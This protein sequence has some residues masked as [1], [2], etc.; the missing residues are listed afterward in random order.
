MLT[1]PHADLIPASLYIGPEHGLLRV[2]R[3]QDHGRI[4]M[5]AHEFMEL[6]LIAEGATLHSFDGQTQVMTAG[7][8]FV[9]LPGEQHSYIDTKRTALYNC[10]FMPGLLER[11][12]ERLA[13]IP[14]LD[15]LYRDNGAGPD[16]HKVRLDVVSRQR[17]TRLLDEMIRE[18][19]ERRTGWQTE[20][21]ALFLS[22]L[23]I[24]ARMAQESRVE[25]EE[26]SAH[27]RQVMQAVEFIESNYQSDYSM[28]D[29]AAAAGLSPS[30]LTRQFRAYLGST[31]IAYAR[32]Y[33]VNRAAELLL[34]TDDSLSTIAAATGYRS[35]SVFSRQFRQLTGQ[36]PSV[37]R[38]EGR[39]AYLN[40]P[41]ITYD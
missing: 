18:S 14:A 19:Q 30:Y 29:V 7:D 12:R 35:L 36:A 22:L 40:D 11:H 2:M 39:V 27:Y 41:H 13:T 33:R 5:H 26:N 1:D 3:Q 28:E 31:P 10:L 8:L 16:L 9:I 20:M 21:E 32:Q 25:L 37:F 15:F 38:R 6:V 24:Y 4:G 34:E 17:V 23:V